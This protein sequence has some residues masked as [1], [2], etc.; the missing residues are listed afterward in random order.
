MRMPL[1]G[2]AS[3]KF[4]DRYEGRWTVLQ[5]VE[6]LTERAT[7][8]RLEPPGVEG[9]GVEFWVRSGQGITYHQAKRQSPKGRAWSIDDVGRSSVAAK[10]F[11]KLADPAASCLFVS[12]DSAGELRE[13]HERARSAANWDEFEREFL[14]A[15]QP[16]TNFDK[17]RAYVKDLTA[18][19]VFDRL[20]RFEIRTIDEATLQRVVE[21][22]LLPLVDGEPS[23]VAAVLAQFALDNVHRE[24]TPGE[25]WRHLEVH[26]LRPREWAK[27]QLVVQAVATRN[28]LY[29]ERLRERTIGGKILGRSESAAVIE[30]LSED[31]ALSGVVISGEAGVGKSVVVLQS[32]DQ[33]LKQ[34]I[35]VLAFRVD[36][37]DPVVLPRDVGKQLGLPDSPAAVLA[38]LAD[39]RPSVLVI[40]QLDAVSLSSGRNPLFFECIEEIIR[41]ARAYA[42]MRVVVV[43]RK[44]DLENDRRFASLVQPPAKFAT[45]TVGR[46]SQEAVA[47]VLQELRLNPDN[48][49]EKQHELLSVPLHLSLLAEVIADQ[50]VD[51][52]AFQTSNDLY[53]RFWDYKQKV[54]QVRLGRPVAWTQTIDALCQYMSEREMLMAPGQILDAYRPDAD[55]MVSEHVLIRGG[56]RYG[57]FHEGFFDYCFARRFIGRGESLIPFLTAKEQHLFRRA[58]VRQVLLH[59]R[60]GG[61]EQYLEDL[62]GLLT[63][64]DIRR[65]VRDVVQSL[66]AGLKDPT[67]E[68]WGV[69][70]RL[71]P[72]TSV[73]VSDQ[74]WRVVHGSVAWFRLLYSLGVLERW[75]SGVDEVADRAVLFLRSAQ[76]QAA[77]EVA[78]LLQPY[79]GRGESWNRRLLHVMQWSDPGAGERFLELFVRLIDV[80]IL[81]QARGPIA[82]NSDFWSLIYG[83]PSQRPDWAAK[84]I[85]HYFTR[86]LVLGIAAGR[87]DPFDEDSQVA[88]ELFIKSARGAPKA[89]VE[90]VLPL[91]LRVMDLN[92]MRDTGA[93]WRDG[94]WRYRQIGGGLGVDDALLEAM[95]IALAEVA[96]GDQDEFVELSRPLRESSFETAQYLLVRAYTAAGAKLA[97]AAVDYLIAGSGRLETGYMGDSHWAARQLIEAISPHCDEARFGRLED[98]ILGH[99][100][101]WERTP[102]GHQSHGHAQF[103]LLGGVDPVRRSPRAKGRYQELERKFGTESVMPPTP[104]EF[105]IVGSPISE[106]AG[107][108][109]TDEQWL[110]AIEKYSRDDM[111]SRGALLTGGAREL[112]RVL[113]SQVKRLPGRFAA[114]VARFP[115]DAHPSYFD[116]VLRGLTPASVDPSVLAAVIRRIHGLPGRPCGRDIAALVGSMNPSTIPENVLDI[117]SWYGTKDTEPEREL[118]RTDSSSGKPLYG[119]DIF[120]AGLNSVRGAAAMAVAHLLFASGAPLARLLPAVEEMVRDPSLAV[121]ACVATVLMSILRHDRGLA[122]RLFLGLVQTEDP[123]L[124]TRDVENFLYYALQTHPSELIPVVE[125]MVQSERPEVRRAGAR[126]ATVIYLQSENAAEIAELALRGDEALRLGAAEIYAANIRR[127]SARERC[128]S[129]LKRLFRDESESVRREAASFAR[130]LEGI[131]IAEVNDVIGDFVDSAAFASDSLSLIHA[132][133]DA[134]AQLPEATLLVCQRFVERVGPEAGDIR[135]RMAMEASTVGKLLVRVYSQ[136][137][138]DGFRSRCLDVIDGMVAIGAFG[139]GEALAAVER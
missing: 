19:E 63:R 95:E 85:G 136:S 110:G 58:Q 29:L 101:Q 23:T 73:P 134:P 55:A 40:D 108:K 13:L 2:G 68:E 96:K 16:R 89:F 59:E 22:Q 126:R 111:R 84:V 77:D 100:P 99:Y 54:V 5:L 37:L 123:L 36:E 26:A 135:S 106:T 131:E 128:S 39:G 66:L 51:S 67:R 124:A 80:G 90:E 10:F 116:A 102:E 15:D 82:V 57:F 1:P 4:G 76:R 12:A 130:H 7:A 21:S 91:M 92:A 35:P 45:V 48:F 33:L 70:E 122:V 52:A 137:R 87:N 132:L 98:A 62:E 86:R 6:L 117:I 43:C 32:L 28:R 138:D 93:P 75:L 3:A 94:V 103:V 20:K 104:V 24:I 56:E 14:K 41:Q 42:S 112:A 119:G 107:E 61:R 81:D 47:N 118:W 69:L 38:A 64:S 11:A 53:G 72:G 25:L 78:E 139:L 133:E 50:S 49:N 34:T 120:T 83:L 109:M 115:D 105:M 65:H 31:A 79:V 125:R 129:A 74:V 97:D 113:E 88:D 121:R 18:V 127:P 27:S 8:L 30:A 44:F 46:L 60:V 114:L 71:P 9:E 17:L